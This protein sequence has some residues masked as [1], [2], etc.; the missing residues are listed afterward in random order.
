MGQSGHAMKL[1]RRKLL[2]LAAGAGAL[3]LMSGIARAQSF[4]ARPITMVV[5]VSAGGAMDTNARLIA[6]GMRAAL[7]QAVVI[8][9][10]T[11]A[12]GSIGVGRVARAVPDG[13]TI[14]YGAFVTHVVNG[15]VYSLAYDVLADFEPVAFIA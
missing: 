1:P 15:V 2:R 3:P 9:N 4:P 7:G 6:E 5:P 8:E 12:S 13:Y 10:V 11:G 14:T